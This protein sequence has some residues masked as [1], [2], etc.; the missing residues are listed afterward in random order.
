MFTAWE[1]T[2]RIDTLDID[3]GIVAVRYGAGHSYQE[4]AFDIYRRYAQACIQLIKMFGCVT[5]GVGLPYEN[6]C[7]RNDTVEHTIN[8]FLRE[9]WGGGGQHRLTLTAFAFML[10]RLIRG[11]VPLAPEDDIHR[12]QRLAVV[13]CC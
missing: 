5:P 7:H 12:Q 11:N 4:L 2:I 1:T 10:S 3:I 13:K 9:G 8:S 6:V